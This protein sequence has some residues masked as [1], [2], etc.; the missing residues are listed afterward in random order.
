M[1]GKK[2][3]LVFGVFAILL[4]AAMSMFLLQPQKTKVGVSVTE[5]EGNWF[6][7]NAGNVA[8]KLK[9][10]NG[11]TGFVVEDIEP[12]ASIAVPKEKE[13]VSL[14]VSQNG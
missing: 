1:I 12:G 10:S 6:V 5:V 2:Q 8:A 9:V 4:A 13:N 3:I 7:K 11:I 14:E